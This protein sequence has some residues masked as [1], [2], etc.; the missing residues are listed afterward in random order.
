MGLDSV[1]LVLSWEE[2]FGI[3]LEDSDVSELVTTTRAVNLISAKVG[4][5]DTVSYCPA[6]RAF[7][8]LREGIRRVTGQVTTAIS[9]DDR[10][11]DVRAGRPKKEF[12]AEF[13]VAIG[14]LGFRRPE[15]LFEQS[16]VRDAVEVL[17]A[18][19]LRQLRKPHE[20]WTRSLVRAG[21]RSGVAYV[22]GVR[23]FS[24][25]DRFVQDLGID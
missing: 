24:D 7:H 8:V 22:I 17:L 6:M 25:D 2:T 9:P 5:V 15:V 10:L 1:E 21:V 18:C 12:W 3:S 4:A 20:P 16:T 23:D 11:S 13:G 19:H 14:L